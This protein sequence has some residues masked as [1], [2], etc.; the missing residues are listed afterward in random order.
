MSA[1]YVQLLLLLQFLGYY[2]V[3]RLFPSLSPPLFSISSSFSPESTHKRPAVFGPQQPSLGMGPRRWNYIKVIIF[4][5][6]PDLCV[7]RVDD[8]CFRFGER[9]ERIFPKGPGN[10]RDEGEKGRN[11]GTYYAQAEKLLWRGKIR[12]SRDRRRRGKQ[13]KVSSGD[14]CCIKYAAISFSLRLTP[15][16]A[17]SSDIETCFAL[18]TAVTTCCWC[19]NKEQ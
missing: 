3:V 8:R 7:E 19:W 6:L 2:R 14:F 5:S 16:M 12:S 13:K 17:F 18:S 15:M 9:R 10:K 4:L 11:K 1:Y